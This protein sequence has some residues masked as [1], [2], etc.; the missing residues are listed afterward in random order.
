MKR[1]FRY[2][3][4]VLILLLI[5]FIGFLKLNPPL[6]HGSIGTTE[7]KQT[8]IVAVG[9]QN[10]IGDIQIT[11][12]ATNN[13]ETPSNVKMQI[14]DSDKGFILT[15]TYA[16]VDESY[17]MQDYETIVLGPDTSPLSSKKVAAATDSNPSTIYGLSISQDTSIDRIEVSYRY[18]GLSFIETIHI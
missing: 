6:A 4:F 12:V 10:W 2:V 1:I 7:D 16:L 8:V 17:D 13:K 14:S 11:N 9:N 15:D 5:S 18:F 3:A